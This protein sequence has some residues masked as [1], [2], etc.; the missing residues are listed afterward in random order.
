M[1]ILRGGGG[2]GHVEWEL[3][4]VVVEVVVVK[5]E[6]GINGL[7]NILRARGCTQNR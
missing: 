4:V 6:G 7:K 5:G 1:C 2:G 3:G